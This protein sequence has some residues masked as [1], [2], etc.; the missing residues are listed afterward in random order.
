MLVLSYPN[1]KEEKK[2]KKKKKKKKANCLLG[3]FEHVVLRN[4]ERKYDLARI[5]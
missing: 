2:K 1:K 5:R 3:F 4:A